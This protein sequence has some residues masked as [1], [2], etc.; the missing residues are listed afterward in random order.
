MSEIKGYVFIAI[1]AVLAIASVILNITREIW[2]FSLFILAGIAMVI[3][4]VFKSRTE[5][6]EK[7]VSH[8]APR[9]VGY[10]SPSAQHRGQHTAGSPQ[11]ITQKPLQHQAAQQ[12]HHAPKNFCSNCGVRLT[13]GATFCANC[14]HRV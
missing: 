14:G 5:A 4:G 1:G 8:A 9:H 7:S 2:N 10:V 13:S 12:V 3:Y 6:P 11:H